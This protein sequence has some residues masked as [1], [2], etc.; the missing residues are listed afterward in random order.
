MPSNWNILDKLLITYQAWKIILI[1]IIFMIKILFYI[2]S[3]KY[4]KM[5]NINIYMYVTYNNLNSVIGLTCM[6]SY[7]VSCFVPQI[8]NMKW[9]M[10]KQLSMNSFALVILLQIR[11]GCMRET[12]VPTLTET[13]RTFLR[14]CVVNVFSESTVMH[15]HDNLTLELKHCLMRLHGIQV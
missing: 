2:T 7:V 5:I 15:L 9:S 13:I 11:A 1:Y 14:H 12:Q 10:V 8:E 6:F 3:S 4:S